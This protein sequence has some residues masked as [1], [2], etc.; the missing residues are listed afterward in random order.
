[1]PVF[2]VMSAEA[3]LRDG[4]GLMLI[5]LATGLVGAFGLLGLVLATIGLY[6]V[7]AY[8]VG[9]RLREFGVR[10]ALGADSASVLRLVVSHGLLMSGVGVTVG[11]MMALG[12]GRL[13]SSLLVGVSPADPLVKI[14]G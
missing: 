13:L 10:I 12:V 8:A 5:R 14:A 4:R 2:D 6:G 9:Q 11:A 3:N 7:V 1:M